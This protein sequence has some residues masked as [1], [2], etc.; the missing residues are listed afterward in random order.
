MADEPKSYGSPMGTEVPGE[1]T[2]ERPKAAPPTSEALK[3]ALANRSAGEAK[4]ETDA[5][6]GGRRL[7]AA[8]DN[9]TKDLSASKAASNIKDKKYRDLKTIDDDS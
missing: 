4:R 3:A 2:R 6:S 9:P 5:P 7:K 8:S 1:T